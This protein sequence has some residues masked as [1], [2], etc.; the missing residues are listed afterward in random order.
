MIVSFSMLEEAAG[1][2]FAQ[3]EAQITATSSRIDSLQ[4]RVEKVLNVI[5]SLEKKDTRVTF[6]S[7]PRFPEM[8]SANIQFSTLSSEQLCDPESVSHSISVSE[9]CI[10]SH[11]VV[12]SSGQECLAA[13]QS[14]SSLDVP[15]I[16]TFS[17]IL[18]PSQACDMCSLQN[19]T[20]PYEAYLRRCNEYRYPLPDYFLN[21]EVIEVSDEENAISD[22]EMDNVVLRETPHY[23]RETRRV[24]LIREEMARPHDRMSLLHSPV[25]LLIL[26]QVYLHR[27]PLQSHLFL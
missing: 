27:Y 14:L 9:D 3:V 13:F 12:S 24:S 8:S 10:H 15:V 18:S 11:A 7:S 1:Q 20:D 2:L 26:N 19:C 23:A 4:C 16:P 6:Y 22:D 21:E 5:S 25:S 17:S